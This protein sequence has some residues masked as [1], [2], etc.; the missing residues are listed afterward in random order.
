MAILQRSERGE[1]SGYVFGVLG[2][3]LLERRVEHDA[4]SQLQV[5]SGTVA[6]KRNTSTYS[7]CIASGNGFGGGK[8]V[9]TSKCGVCGAQM[10]SLPYE[11]AIC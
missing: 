2:N 3:L 4:I 11:I 1:V 7:V 6:C 10:C 8:Y 9:L 5:L